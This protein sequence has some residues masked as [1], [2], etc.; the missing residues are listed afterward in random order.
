M[1]FANRDL[2]ALSVDRDKIRSPFIEEIL[3]GRGEGILR[4]LAVFLSKY[5]KSILASFICCILYVP[6]VLGPL[7]DYDH[8]FSSLVLTNPKRRIRL[9][10]RTNSSK[11]L[12]NSLHGAV[13]DNTNKLPSSNDQPL[14]RF[15]RAS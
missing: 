4:D 6:G 13:A 11:N 12:G 7:S 8:K 9:S 3:T 2:M 1:S 10:K 15:V 14:N 5:I